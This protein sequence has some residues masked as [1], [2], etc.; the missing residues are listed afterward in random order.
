MNV[1]VVSADGELDAPCGCPECDKSVQPGHFMCAPAPNA[2][3]HWEMHYCIGS[4]WEKHAAAILTQAG[5]GLS[6]RRISVRPL[7][8][9]PTMWR[10]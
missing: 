3:L 8:R 1:H 7:P 6:Q 9:I 10:G 5:N 2:L 4:G